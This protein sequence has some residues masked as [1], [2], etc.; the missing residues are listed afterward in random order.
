M[1]LSFLRKRLFAPL[2]AS[3]MLLVVLLLAQEILSVV[4]GVSK[5][6]TTDDISQAFQ[7][8]RES[9]RLLRSALEEKVALRGYLLTQN[10]DFL[11]QYQQGRE[12]S[13][14]SLQRLSNLLVND[15]LQQITL[16]NI[17]V[18]HAQWSQK[19][20]QPI[21]SNSF[22][23]TILESED[24]SL[25]PLRDAVDQILTY[26]Q[27]IINKQNERLRRLERL[28]V[29]GLGLNIA[30]VGL[31]V[32][33][34]GLNL[35]LLRRRVL[36]PLNQLIQV[37][38]S[39]RSGQLS[40]R[41]NHNSEDVMGQLATT[42]NGMAEG[43]GVRQAHI[44]TRNQ[45]LEDLIGTLS[46]DLRTPLLANRSM[47]NAML[48][49]A[50]G[51]ISDRLQDVLEDYREGNDNLITLVETLLDISRYEAGGS[52]LLNRKP[53]DWDHICDRVI[54]WIRNS[55]ANKCRLKVRIAYD[56]PTVCGDAIEIQRVLQNLV[57]NAVRVS[58]RGQ[59]VLIDV[60][61]P[62]DV[63]IQVAVYD[64]GPGLKE[65]DASQLF[66]RFSQSPGRQGRAGLGLYLC[67][68][69]IEAH[70]GKIWVDSQLQRGATFLF[71]LPI[72]LPITQKPSG[73]TIE[74][75][76]PEF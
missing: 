26:E 16:T 53:L 4:V 55:S 27:A 30:G 52:Q 47:L 24:S 41:I 73:S 59:S 49:G 57:D 72:S 75:D 28:N 29:L 51:P 62:N 40:R 65:Q 50:F 74:R 13:E 34:T 25:D 7:I 48:G 17:K 18:F 21:I 19:F 32:I 66:Y 63:S 8:K 15:E 23:E 35:I 39:W 10:S 11:Q 69:I 42:L 36:V 58:D 9:E 56:L 37:G 31:V 45:Q 67:R 14:A 6:R 3:F 5:Q 38:S 61:A 76:H 1:D 54:K 60:S 12:T 33:G 70:G 43:I 20:A 71:S 2:H 64:Q 46:H 68:Q 44:Q 22:D